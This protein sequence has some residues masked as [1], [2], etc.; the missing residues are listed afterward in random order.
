M[1]F[2]E[3]KSKQK[4][5]ESE[6]ILSKYLYPVYQKF[7]NHKQIFNKYPYLTSDSRIKICTLKIMKSLEEAEKLCKNENIITNN[8]GREKF[9]D[10]LML[11]KYDLDF[12]TIHSEILENIIVN[13]NDSGISDLEINK[14]EKNK[15]EIFQIQKMKKIIQKSIKSI[16]VENN[17]NNSLI[18][19]KETELK[20]EKIENVINNKKCENEIN[21]NDI[22]KPKEKIENKNNFMINEIVQKSFNEEIVQKEEEIINY[23]KYNKRND[24]NSNYNNLT[25]KYEIKNENKKRYR[26]SQPFLKTFNTKFIKKENI[27]KKIFRK[28]RKYF[29][30][31]YNE[32][33]NLSIFQRNQIFWKKF[34]SENLL[35]PL[36]IKSYNDKILE[37]K[38]F[39]AQYLIWLFSQEGISELFRIFIDNEGENIIKD[40][41]TEYNLAQTKDVNIVDK[42]R[43]YINKI[44][45]IYN[46]P[47]RK[48]ILDENTECY[49]TEFNE[50]KDE[51]K[52]D[53]G[54]DEDYIYV[55]HSNDEEST[56]DYSDEE[57]PVVEVNPLKNILFGNSKPKNPNGIK[58]SK[59]GDAIRDASR[60]NLTK[61]EVETVHGEII[62]EDVNEHK[63][64]PNDDDVVEV[65]IISSDYKNNPDVNPLRDR[66]IDDGVIQSYNDDIN[67]DDV[68]NVIFKKNVDGMSEMTRNKTIKEKDFDRVID[69]AFENHPDGSLGD[70]DISNIASALVS[71]AFDDVISDTLNKKNDE[72]T[73]FYD[74]D[75]DNYQSDIV[76]DD[77]NINN[78]QKTNKVSTSPDGVTYYKGINDVNSPLRKNNL[79][80][81][82]DKNKSKSVKD[83]IK[84]SIRD[85]KYIHKS[86]NEIENPTEVGYVSVVDRTEE[87]DE[88]DYIEPIQDYEGEEYVPQDEGLTFAEKEELRYE[89]E[90]QMEKL[91]KELSSDDNTIVTIHEEERREDRKD[92]ALEDIIQIADEDYKEIEKERFKNSNTLKS[93]DDNKLP[94]RGNIEDE[95]FDYKFASD[96]GLNSQEDLF[97]QPIDN[98][99][100]SINEIVNVEG[101]VHVN[102]VVKRVKDSCHIKRAGSKMKKQ[103]LKAIKES[104][105]SGN[106]IRIG[107]FLYDASSNDVVIRKRV[108]PKI[109]LISDEEISKNIETILSHKQNITTASLTREVSRNFGFKSTSR[110]TSVKI[111]SVLDSMIAEGT[112][113]LDKDIVELN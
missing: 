48:K 18:N 76:N 75:Y 83:S 17:E 54:S 71:K 40:F 31:Y 69:E 19:S 111:K 59:F 6:K 34:N 74:D 68:D 27:D 41:I 89:R 80:Y 55:D 72:Y 79:Y 35:P 58:E 110:K 22:I 64:A 32:N 25:N 51:D 28:F 98:V 86:L 100:N 24:P 103:V 10:E 105:N 15:N 36:K 49:S 4:Y 94:K 50:N 1:V 99:S 30:K 81:D 43:N 11:E 45:E 85:I 23:K 5:A 26:D 112:V 106:I 87:Y 67:S 56:I 66:T 104:E 57:P 70:D 109:D 82:G 108:K 12:N 2:Y 90:L 88:N 107:D 38:S 65:E 7:S 63:P 91:K 101:P 102:E 92:Q 97:N 53:L 96:F 60:I 62:D 52:V 42:L 61:G 93:F 8:L 37:F 29:K 14:E 84:S 39:N 9:D 73:Q 78:N 47:D 44:P 95:I 33:K 3:Y 16:F 13:E 77:I 20:Q 46:S 21:S 113:K